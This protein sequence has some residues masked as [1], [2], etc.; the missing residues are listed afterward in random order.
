MSESKIGGVSQFNEM[1]ETFSAFTEVAE[2]IMK[3]RA[4]LM[5]SMALSWGNFNEPERIAAKKI[6]VALSKDG[7]LQLSSEPNFFVAFRQL[8]QKRAVGPRTQ[9]SL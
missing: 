7:A 5:H 9:G 6:L 8:A 3:Q 2:G 1:A 4:K